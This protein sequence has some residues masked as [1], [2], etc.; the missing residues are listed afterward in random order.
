MGRQ[1]GFTLVEILIV[2]LL[3]GVLAAIVLPKFSNASANARTSMLASD[4]QTL[5]TQIT[6]FQAQHCGVAAGYPDGNS[7]AVPTEADFV[8]H[9]TKA[10]N[11]SFLTAEPGTP[12]FEHGPYLRKMPENPVNGKNTVQVIANNEDFPV[13]GNDSHGWIYKP[14]TLTLKADSPGTD[15][16]GKSYF[17]Y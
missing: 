15:D 13:A 2:V 4:L 14:A 6:V 12:G 1:K 11:N 9:M 3:L 10:S 8:L 5:R 16:N 17:S 7:S